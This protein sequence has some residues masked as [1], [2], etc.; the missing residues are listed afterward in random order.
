[1]EEIRK[2]VTEKLALYVGPGPEQVKIFIAAHFLKY[3]RS[4]LDRF[5]H[6]DKP[7]WIPENRCADFI[8]FFKKIDKL[9]KVCKVFVA[10]WII[11]KSANEILL[12]NVIYDCG[13]K[14]M[15]N[16]RNVS[17]E[18]KTWNLINEILLR[19]AEMGA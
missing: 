16:S 9:Y 6:P 2:Q 7:F 14:R 11:K 15:L 5:L 17:L 8:K 1:M 12:M 10:G 19:Q 18:T 13:M 4:E 3:S